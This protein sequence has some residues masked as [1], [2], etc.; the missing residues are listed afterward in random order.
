MTVEKNNSSGN[1]GCSRWTICIGV[2]AFIALCVSV[3]TLVL[4]FAGLIPIKSGEIEI[5]NNK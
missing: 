2:M 5:I 1:A 3:A 4:L